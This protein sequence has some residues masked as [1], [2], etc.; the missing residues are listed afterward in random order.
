MGENV[1]A[2]TRINSSEDQ[3][4][5]NGKIEKYCYADIDYNC[6]IYGGLYQWREMMQYNPSDTGEIGTTQGICPEGWH[7]PTGKEWKKL[8][9]Y[10]GGE[11]IAG[12][13][14]KETG[15]EHWFPP[16]TCA[17]NESGFTGLPGGNFTL[18]NENIPRSFFYKGEVGCWWSANIH[19]PTDIVAYYI[20]GSTSCEFVP[21]GPGV[22]WNCAASVRCVKDP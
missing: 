4:N 14:M 7:L 16:N 22:N 5:N 11:D 17:T 10:L 12:G 21:Y 19:V 13:K 1:N 20:L 6:D 15:T 8:T 2:G 9:E 18:L 3:T